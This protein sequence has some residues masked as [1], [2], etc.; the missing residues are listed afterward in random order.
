MNQK[1]QINKVPVAVTKKNQSHLARCCT[2][3]GIGYCGKDE[4]NWTP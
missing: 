4:L 1:N 2:E 3:P